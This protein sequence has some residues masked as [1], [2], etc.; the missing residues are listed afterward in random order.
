MRSS[1]AA[2]DLIVEQEISSK[3]VY[4][5]RYQ[6]PTW[7]KNVSGVT[8]GIGYDLGYSTADIVLHDW[9]DFLDPGMIK[10]MQRCC[11]VTGMSARD[12]LPQVKQNILVPWDAAMAVFINHDMPKW[13]ATVLKA[14]PGSDKLPAG[15]FGVLTSLAYN[16]GASFSKAGDRYKEMRDIRMHV[17]TGQWDMVPDDIRAM[18]HIWEGQKGVEGLLA[19]RDAEA[20]LWEASLAASHPLP[21]DDHED[22]PGRVDTG[23]DRDDVTPTGN[24]PSPIEEVPLN[25]QVPKATYSLEVEL[26]QRT[27]IAMNYFEVGDPDGIVGGKFVAG[28]A[29][30][31]T[32]RGKDPNKGKITPELRAELDIAKK[33]KLPDGRPWTRPIA[34]ARANATTT[35]LAPKVASVNFNW[36]QKIGA[37]LLGVP[38]ALAA[39]FK[40][41]FGEQATPQGY[42]QAVKDFFGAIPAEFYWLGVASLAVWIFMAA[43]KAQDATVKDY[44]SGKIN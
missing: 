24:E 39:G 36:Y 4:I 26:I 1:K 29:A 11:G 6:H 21:D 14:I 12:L 9:K 17:A 23:D 18:K 35:D 25:V 2:V 13:E 7:P 5:K 43:K 33:E 42:A 32:D 28:V 34:P 16:R 40:A 20:D 15:C 30:F 41:V 44:Q 37:F 22:A 10:Q 27:L 38:S 8:V 19:R 31:M 3:A